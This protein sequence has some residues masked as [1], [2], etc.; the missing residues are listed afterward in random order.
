M[1]TGSSCARTA[2]WGE[3]AP[4][5]YYRF[6]PDRKGERPQGHLAGFC[7]VIQADAF[8]GYERLARSEASSG[9][10]APRILHTAC[11]AHARRKFF[12]V[13]EAT[14][15][16]IAE[17]ALR[18]IGELYRIEAEISG[19]PA[20]LRLAARQEHAV[21]ILAELR[22][23]L[24]EQR[25]RLSSKTALAKAIQYALTRWMRSR[26]TPAMVVSPSTT[27]PPNEAYAASLSTAK[28]SCSSA[29]RPAANA[30]PY[31]TPC[32]RPRSSTGSILKPI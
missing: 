4:A 3:R 15:S 25:R 29:P 26:A 5:A 13:F 18:R 23:W 16:P 11:W 7:G 32:W 2:R 19:R 28:T 1:P 6:S 31:S 12:D 14:K 30:P 8:S 21:S 9:Q 17:E 22:T 24:E 20:E 10:D 27:I